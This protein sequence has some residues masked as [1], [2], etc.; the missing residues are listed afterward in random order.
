MVLGVR[1]WFTP[2]W[3]L[4]VSITGLGAI[5]AV[6]WELADEA[7]GVLGGFVAGCIVT[8]VAGRR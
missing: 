7:L 6:L 2:A 4:L 5:L 3:V 1:G 8:R